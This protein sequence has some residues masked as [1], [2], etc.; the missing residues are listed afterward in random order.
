MDLKIQHNKIIKFAAA[1]ENMIENKIKLDACDSCNEN[2]ERSDKA[3]HDNLLMNSIKKRNT[4][5]KIE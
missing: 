3:H 2:A 5:A 1:T 4:M